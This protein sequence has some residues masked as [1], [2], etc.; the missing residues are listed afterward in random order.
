LCRCI[1]ATSGTRR[2]VDIGKGDV[3]LPEET[4]RIVA[5][6]YKSNAVDPCLDEFRCLYAEITEIVE[7]LFA[8]PHHTPID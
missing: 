8:V 7:S 3:L 2:A 4:S 1:T 6:L 5:G